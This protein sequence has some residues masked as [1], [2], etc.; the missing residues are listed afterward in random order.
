MNHSINIKIILLIIV[1]IPF[2]S[3]KSDAQ[4]KKAGPFTQFPNRLQWEDEGELFWIE[5]FGANALRFRGTISLRIADQNWN[6]INQPDVPIEITISKDSATL[7][8]GKIRAVVA[9]RRGRIT[10]YNDKNK[11]LL[12]EAYHP[13]HPHFARQ[14]STRG[15]DRF[16]V[17]LTFDADKDEKLYGM[18]Q[19]PNGCLNLKGCVLELAQKNTQISIPF[20]LSNKGYGFI[21]NNPA[22]GRAELAMTHTSFF[23]EYTKQID[24]VIFPGDTPGEIVRHYSTLTGTAPEIP[25]YATGLW[26]SKLRYRTQDELLSVAKEYKKRNLPISV[27]VIDFHHWPETGDFKFDEKYWPDV[28]EMIKELDSMHIKLLVSVWPTLSPK[29]ENYRTF[30]KN[31]YTI[32]PELGNNF[33]LGDLT[34]IDATYPAARKALWS[35]LKENYWDQG[36]QMFWLDESEPEIEPL[37]YENIRY[38]LGNGLEVSNIYPYYLAKAIY[39]GQVEAGQKEIINLTRSGWIGTQTLGTVLWSGDINGDFSTLRKQVKAGLNISLCGIPWWTTDIGGFWGH[40]QKPGYTELMIRWFQYGTFCPIMRMHGVR[41]PEKKEDGEKVGS[42][43]GNEVWSYGDQAL[44]IMTHYL[45]IREKLRPYIKIQMDKA[46]KDGTPVMRPLFYDFPDDDEC[47]Q[48]EDQF[49]FGPDI[50][51]APILNHDIHSRNVYLPNGSVW[52]NALT[53]KKFTGGRSIN[54]KVS[55]ENIPVFTRNN[56]DFSMKD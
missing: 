2:Y 42:G 5:P 23:A 52:T 47:Y 31:N 3:L 15:S 24:Y 11:V 39:D 10:Y 22:I 56:L 33:F 18:G 55:L 38:Y 20:L 12:K 34:Y 44:S 30:V 51:V 40:P 37:Q 49:M 1:L 21:W 28:P 27:I 14:Y 25:Y 35:K 43:L 48:I 6:L 4:V 53:G 26:Q 45:K 9:A 46:S 8:N 16:Q 54:V 17:K 29:S 19:Y 7:K 41:Y 50:L 13:H 36:V 32:R